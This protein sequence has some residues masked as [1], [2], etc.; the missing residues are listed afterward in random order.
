MKFAQLT[1]FPIVLKGIVDISPAGAKVLDANALRNEII[2]ELVLA[3]VFAQD[4]E[5]RDTARWLIWET[6]HQLGATIASI[7]DL[8]MARGQEKYKDLCVPAV[9]LRAMTYDKARAMFRAANGINSGAFIFEIAKSE[10]GYTMQRPAE[11]TA[12][13]LAAAI[14]EGYEGP[15]FIQGDH[16]Q[17]NAKNYKQDPAKE[18]NAVKELIEEAVPAGFYNIDIDTSTLV[19]LDEPTVPEQQRLNY[20]LAAELTAY[21]RN[22]E[23]KG[24]TVSVGGEIGEVGGKNSNIEEMEAYMDGYTQSLAKQ[25]PGKPGLSK[26]SVQTGTSHG[27][28]VLPD[29]SIAKVALDFSVLDS[30]GKVARAKYGMSGCVQHGASTLPDEAFHNFTSS[31]ASEVHLATGFQNLLYDH[32]SFPADLR[33]RVYG[34]LAINC[35]KE[36]KPGK[37]DEQFFYSTRKKGFGPYKWE[38]WTLPE[39]IKAPILKDLEAK[40]SFL[41]NQ[42]GLKDRRDVTREFVK[43]PFI[44]KAMPKALNTLLTDPN[45]Y[46]AARGPEEDA[47][48]AD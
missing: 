19:D 40:F 15:V 30:L 8:Y 12:A 46:G 17:V 2:D 13:V 34:W 44:A 18:L 39:S 11:Y 7:H 6:G 38:T 26:I 1:D 35:A 36:R 21:I 24:I 45:R 4:E 10:I 3:A 22:L 43:A 23:P 16:F 25:A 14:K 29:G 33:E 41:F 31:Q 32:A 28:V 37:T 48:G 27:G 9:N 42:L 5:V 20:E 47:P